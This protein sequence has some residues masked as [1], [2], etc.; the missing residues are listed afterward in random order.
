M[1]KFVTLCTFDN[2]IEA[3]IVKGLLESENVAVFLVGEHFFGVQVM[4]NVGLAHIRMQVPAN[5]LAQAKQ[6][7]QDYRQGALEQPL[8]DSF[9]AESQKLAPNA[10]KK[11]GCTEMQQALSYTSLTTNIV[12]ALYFIGVVMPPKKVNSCKQCKTKIT[13]E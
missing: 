10:C 7:L 12:L 6:L 8:V 4:L 3:H 5:Q 9:E 13:E 11:C 1:A 2:A